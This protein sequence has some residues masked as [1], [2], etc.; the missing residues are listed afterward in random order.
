MAVG[1]I[2]RLLL[3]GR[4]AAG[5]NVPVQVNSAGS[6]IVSPVLVTETV[7]STGNSGAGLTTVY[8]LTVPANTLKNNGDALVIEAACSLAANATNKLSTI[9]FGGTLVASRSGVA[10]NGLFR[11]HR[12]TIMRTGA[13]TQVASGTTTVAGGINEDGTS[14]AETLANAITV[15]FKLQG[16][17]DNDLVAKYM[18]IQYM[19][20]GTLV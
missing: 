2:P 11:K 3:F 18:F 12:A 14:P 19:P 7:T 17:A 9:Q 6:L 5:V 10:D 4:T 1:S 15:L 16:G 20:A 13:T 8:T